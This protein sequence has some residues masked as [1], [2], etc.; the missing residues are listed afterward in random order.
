MKGGNRVRFH[1]YGPFN[2]T[3]KMTVP[4]NNVSCSVLTRSDANKDV[5]LK[6]KGSKLHYIID[7]KGTFSMPHLFDQTIGIKRPDYWK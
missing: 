6:V 1:T 4:I 3:K 5:T 7:N 2:T